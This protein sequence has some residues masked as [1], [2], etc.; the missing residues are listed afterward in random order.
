[1]SFTTIP[2]LEI[3]PEKYKGF[4]CGVKELDEYL[5][6]FAKTNHKK[7]IGKSFIEIRQ[8]FA[9]GYYTIC[10]GAVEFRYL[11]ENLRRGIPRYPVPVARIGRLAVDAHM[12]GRRLGAY[13]LWDALQRILVAS[14]QIAAYA[15]V[16]DA[17]NDS[18][19]G[20]YEHHGFIP[21]LNDPMSLFLPLETIQQVKSSFAM[22]QPSLEKIEQPT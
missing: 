8:D 20:F 12:Q 22:V 3:A 18:A 19:K 14:T 6:R 4:T 11:P 9:V 17:K 1:M 2:I 13:L 5:K 21:F 10:M 16:V 15:V 7:G